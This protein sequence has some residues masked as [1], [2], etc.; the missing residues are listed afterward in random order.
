MSAD[1]LDVFQSPTL[2]DGCVEH[3]RTFKAQRKRLSGISRRYLMFENSFTHALGYWHSKLWQR[4]RNRE[5]R[6]YLRAVQIGGGELRRFRWPHVGIGH[7]RALDRI[8]GAEMLALSERP[9]VS[10]RA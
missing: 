9:R 1:H 2:T 3:H 6:P 7:C 10:S 4:N 5:Q 8:R